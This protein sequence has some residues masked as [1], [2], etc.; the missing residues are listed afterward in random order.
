MV[1]ECFRARFGG[2]CGVHP[3]R[4]TSLANEAKRYIC[5]KGLKS[6]DSQTPKTV[7]PQ[8]LVSCEVVMGRSGSTQTRI[9]MVTP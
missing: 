2:W 5:N 6:K 4:S 8:H 1:F 3:A 7:I 9:A